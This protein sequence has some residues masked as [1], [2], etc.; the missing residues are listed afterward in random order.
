MPN[1]GPITRLAVSTASVCLAAALSGCGAGGES[2]AEG[3]R[4][5]VGSMPAADA[6][7][8]PSPAA[9]TTRSLK[10]PVLTFTDT[11][12]NVD[13]GV[14]FNGKW[15]VNSEVGWEYSL[16]EGQTWITGVGDQFDVQGDG[17]KMIWVR[18]RDDMGNTS[19]IVMVRCVLDT[20]P[21]AA[22]EATP[23]N[24]GVTRLLSLSGLEPGGRWEY[25][26]DDRQTWLPG[27]GS[28]LAVLGNGLSSLWL[29]QV[30]LA[31]NP[32]VPQAV[33]LDT[34][35]NDAWHEASGDP[36]QPSVLSTA[37][38]QTLLLHG[39]V[40]R[41]DADYVRWDVPA[42]F[43]IASLRLVRYVS[44]DPIAFYALQRAPVF[45]AGVD[46]SRMLVYGHMGP[47]DLLR[48]VLAAVPADARGEG[49]M[50]LWFQQTGP[51][52]TA[53]AIELVL[54]PAQ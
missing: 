52:P 17:S 21:P 14:T 49:P 33:V 42:G 37:Q 30:D 3:D 39:S 44:D 20:T 29:R 28:G 6:A 32:S 15:W 50:T 5:V 35:A 9:P 43:R 12:L 18:S 40:I 26:V 48:N 51:L 16:D 36:L 46:V 53:Y 41:G 54:Q 45:D 25:S 7:L 38:A 2:S 34:P 1:R 22:V 8:M 13:D 31:G 4:I 47:P 19:E 24:Q 23:V 11:G 10:P 27:S